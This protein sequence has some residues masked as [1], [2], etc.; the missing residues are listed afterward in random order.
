MH[1]SVDV[2]VFYRYQAIGIN[3]L[4][5]LLV[6]KVSPLETNSLMHSGDYFTFLMAKGRTLFGFR[7][8]ALN[9]SEFFFFL[10]KETWVFNLCTVR[11][12]SKGLKAHINAYLVGVRWQ[13]ARLNL[14]R[15]ADI[16]LAGT[17]TGKGS[18]F[19]PSLYWPVQLDGDVTDFGDF[20]L[21]VLYLTAT[22]SLGKSK[23]IVTAKS[24][25][26][27]IAWLLSGFNSTEKSLKSKVYPNRYVLQGLSITRHKGRSNRFQSWQTDSLGVVVRAF[28]TLLIRGFTFGQKVIVKPPHFFKL[29]IKQGFLLVSWV[30]AVFERLNHTNIIS[31]L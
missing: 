6:A 3:N 12:G 26:A 13:A 10:S 7:Q 5:A 30:N 25:E 18:G 20:E 22:F 11:Q 24:F 2:Q 14:N 15:E 23:A 19:N 8:L 29:N 17:G 21:T 28:A 9:F 27:G 1:H 31:Y 16:P 4:S